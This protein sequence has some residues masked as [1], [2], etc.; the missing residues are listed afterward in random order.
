MMNRRN[1]RGDR[2]WRR[3]LRNGLRAPHRWASGAGAADRDRWVRVRWDR[4]RD[5]APA[6]ASGRVR[7][8]DPGAAWARAADAVN[9]DRAAAWVPVAGAGSSARGLT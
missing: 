8:W 4:A 9:S 3:R 7:A 1:G 2:W 5:A 6:A